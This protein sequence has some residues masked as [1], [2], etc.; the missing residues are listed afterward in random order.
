[1]DLKRSLAIM[2]TGLGADG[3]YLDGVYR[4]FQNFYGETHRAYHTLPHIA[5]CLR[6]LARAR[7]AGL[8]RGAPEID[9]AIWFHD[10]VYQPREKGN[11]ETSAVLAHGILTMAGVPPHAIAAVTSYVR[12][13]AHAR[14][15]V[16]SNPNLELFLDIDLA[17]LG[18]PTHEF[19]NYE[20]GIR[21]E[22][23]VV[24]AE[25]FCRVRADILRGFLDRPFRTEYFERKYGAAARA[26]LEASIARLDAG[27]ILT[28]QGEEVIHSS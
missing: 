4:L 27:R 18:R 28:F 12:A 11:E 8:G 17:I 6:E 3:N 24:A 25:T 10:L 22:Y 19:E 2:W 20:R 16:V 21:H 7:R 13:S 1:M 15:S 23:N 5:H 26:N 9:A 14:Q